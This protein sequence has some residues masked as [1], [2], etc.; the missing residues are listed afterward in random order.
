MRLFRI[1]ATPFHFSYYWFFSSVSFSLQG[2]PD[3]ARSFSVFILP[4]CVL[5]VTFRQVFLRTLYPANGRWRRRN[6]LTNVITV[7]STTI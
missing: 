6:K 1:R 5:R 3:L 2:H 7:L 4:H